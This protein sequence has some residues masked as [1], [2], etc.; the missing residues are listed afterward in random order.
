MGVTEK[1][2]LYIPISECGKLVKVILNS[3]CYELVPP[4]DLRSKIRKHCFS[5][6]LEFGNFT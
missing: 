3:F 2:T 4:K 1:S 5:L 6:H